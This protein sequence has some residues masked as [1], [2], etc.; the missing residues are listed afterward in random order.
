MT[1]TKSQI[2]QFSVQFKEYDEFNDLLKSYIRLNYHRNRSDWVRFHNS[3]HP[4]EFLATY[5]ISQIRNAICCTEILLLLFS[6][7]E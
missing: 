6:N 3:L 4:L 1:R 2:L 5:D 7:S